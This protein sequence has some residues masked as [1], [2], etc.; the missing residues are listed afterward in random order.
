[1]A[2]PDYYRIM[3]PLLKFA[4]DRKEHSF[5]ESME[6][7]NK[8]FKLTEE[9]KRAVL[10]C[11]TQ[12]IIENRVGSARIYLQKAGLIEYVRRG[13]FKI[14][15]RG[16]KILKQNPSGI[17]VKSLMQ[18]PEFVKFQTINWTSEK[19][20]K[21]NLEASASNY[22]FIEK[23][24]STCLEYV[25]LTEKHLSVYSHRL[26]SLIVRIGPEI[27]RTFNIVLF[28]ENRSCVLNFFEVKPLLLQLQEKIDRRRDCLIDYL[29]VV[30]ELWSSGV[31]SA[32]I[33]VPSL[34]KFILPFEFGTRTNVSGKKFATIPWWEDGYNALRH[35]MTKE[36]REAAT[37]KN[38]L[39]SLAALWLL[40]DIFKRDF[41]INFESEIFGEIQDKS[42]VQKEELLHIR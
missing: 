23:E 20:L 18:F 30:D 5:P 28:N 3:H 16:L 41:R 17:Y 24:F 31:S 37:L 15:N 13:H 38:S 8:L 29:I 11:G 42:S 7:L 40:H 26:A 14:T 6:H 39:Y 21:E 35:R 2:I 22:R 10:P 32:A 33:R 34:D 1:M 12:R 9:E 4:G 27:L 19:I 25:A 36:F